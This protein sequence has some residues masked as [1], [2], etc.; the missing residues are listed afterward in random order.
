MDDN[1]DTPPATTP[2]GAE[3]P[4]T[5]RLRTPPSTRLP[6]GFAA[7]ALVGALVVNYL[8]NRLPLGG[9]TTG[10]LSALYPN[11]F[12]PAGITFSIWGVIYLLVGAWTVV[13][14][15]P[16]RAS[17][18]MRI[19][20]AF[21]ASSVLNA[22]WLV[23]WHDTRVGLSVGIMLGLLA[24][25]LYINVLLRDAEPPVPLLPRLAFGIYLGWVLVATLVNVTA[26][27]VSVGWEGGGVS[28]ANWA[29]ILVVV[30]TGVAVVT[31][32]RLRTPFPGL[33][34]GWAFAGI[35]LNRWND[36]P[37]VAWTA[38]VMILVVAA[39]TLVT[40]MNSASPPYSGGAS[41]TRRKVA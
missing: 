8:A 13:Q 22:A 15:F 31:M 28:P 2:S 38:V 41:P 19:A 4:W 12:V 35:A 20:P 14:F 27:L 10:E 1:T 7:L 36:A 11:L 3:S 39:A 9:R 24:V 26:F 25:L 29:S 5:E 34:V 30:G 37:V 16:S 17:L 18:G 32:R 23:A 40:S 6:H 33:A 21:A